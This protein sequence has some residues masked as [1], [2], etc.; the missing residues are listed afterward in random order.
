MPPTAMIASLLT[1]P[2]QCRGRGQDELCTAG[3]MS[4]F[5]ISSPSLSSLPLSTISSSSNP[6]A[7]GGTSNFHFSHTIHLS[8]LYIHHFHHFHRSFSPLPL[9]FHLILPVLLA[10]SR[11]PA[12]STATTSPSSWIIQPCQKWRGLPLLHRPHILLAN[13]PPQC[14]TTL[15]NPKTAFSRSYPQPIPARKPRNKA[16]APLFCPAKIPAG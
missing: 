5:S 4:S 1:A 16:T 3:K 12:S 6:N 8:I 13:A 11:I 15:S 14:S 9:Q 7:A 2:G 10:S